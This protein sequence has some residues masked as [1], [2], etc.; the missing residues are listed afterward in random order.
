MA[1][2][3]DVQYIQLKADEARK[4]GTSV[5]STQSQL[6]KRRE[7]Q[8]AGRLKGGIAGGLLGLALSPFTGGASL[9]M[10]M[11]AG[12]GSWLG[13]V[14]GVDSVKVDEIE[15]GKLF[16]D[17]VDEARADS[18]DA[19]THLDQL[20]RTQAWKDAYTAWNIANM[21]GGSK[22]GGAIKGGAET[23]VAS[24]GDGAGFLDRVLATSKGGVQGALDYGQQ[25]LYKHGLSNTYDSPFSSLTAQQTEQSIRNQIG[26]EATMSYDTGGLTAEAFNPR[27][28]IETGDLASQAYG[29]ELP[30]LPEELRFDDINLPESPISKNISGADLTST[31]TFTLGDHTRI[32]PIDS[33]RYAPG[34]LSGYDPTDIV[35]K[36]EYL[37]RRF[38]LQ[39]SNNVAGIVDF[40][41]EGTKGAPES[42][43]NVTDD[44]LNI[45]KKIQERHPINSVDAIDDFIRPKLNMEDSVDN[46][47]REQ[48]MASILGLGEKKNNIGLIDF[49]LGPSLG[50]R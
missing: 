42:E 15:K 22:L 1:S 44:I 40:I 25:Q 4:F 35:T 32:Q 27:D 17:N 37:N 23:S 20:S 38:P 12:V 33:Q 5:Q 18:A 46:I 29:L 6:N 11:G 48:L 19:I 34:S 2:L 45:I 50:G 16:K 43:K 39:A 28:I 21:V 14:K 10:A 41:N 36:D 49:L 7:K 31:D 3:A 13:A 9:M 8:G 26:Q 47:T 24:L 30:D